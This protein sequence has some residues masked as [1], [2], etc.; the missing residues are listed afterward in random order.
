[1]NIRNIFIGLAILV[2]VSFVFAA[3]Q[4]STSVSWHPLQQV[5]TDEGGGTSVDADYNSVIDQA[6]NINC[7]DATCS[8]TSTNGEFEVSGGDLLVRDGLVI[9]STAPDTLEAGALWLE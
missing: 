8:I 2:L 4:F 3:T 9:P 1:M 7:D 6:E 5:T